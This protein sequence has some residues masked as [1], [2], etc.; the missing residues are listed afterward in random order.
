MSREEA[1]FFIRS[2]AFDVKWGEAVAVYPEANSLLSGWILGE[3]ELLGKTAVAD[4]PMGNGRAVLIGFPPIF[5]SQVHGTF[6]VLFNS[7]LYS[8]LEPV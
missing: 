8:T 4:L 3:K 6:K 7:L 5:R 2:K 1:I